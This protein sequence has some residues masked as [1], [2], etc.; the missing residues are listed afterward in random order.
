MQNPPFRN[1]FVLCTGRCGSTSFERACR[2]ATN[3]TSGHET[4]SHL[5]GADR[6]AYPDRHIEA[7]KSH[8]AAIQALGQAP[9]FKLKK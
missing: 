9:K 4:R 6:L 8:A 1:V 3:W 2:H 5:L 7:D